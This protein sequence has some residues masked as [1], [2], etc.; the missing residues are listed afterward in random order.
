M[1]IYLNGDD[2]DC[3]PGTTVEQLIIAQGLAPT[4]VAVEINR[5]LVPRGVRGKRVLMDDDRVELVTLVGGG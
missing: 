2:H 1:H 5:E 4:L 3:P